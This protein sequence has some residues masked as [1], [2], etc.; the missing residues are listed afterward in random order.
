MSEQLNNGIEDNGLFDEWNK[1][2]NERLDKFKEN[3]AQ[4]LMEREMN[5]E[6]KK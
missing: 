6:L 5:A 3:A 2:A 4:E 1:L